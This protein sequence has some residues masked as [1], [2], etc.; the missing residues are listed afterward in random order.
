MPQLKAYHRPTTISEAV[1]L[2]A[3]PAVNTR[4]IGGGTYAIPH[5]SDVVDEVV[6]LQKIGL[7]EITT[8]QHGLNVGAMVTLQT[9]TTDARLPELLRQTAQQ[10]GPNTLRQAAT[11]GG[12]VVGANKESELLAA[13]LIF[14]A[15]IKVQTSNGSKTVTLTDFLQDVPTALSGGI[16]TT[17]SLT[18]TGQ[19][20]QARAARTPTDN[21]IVAAIA[22][23]EGDGIIQLALCGVAN[24]PVLV[25]PPNIETAINPPADF[26][27]ST[28]YR[29]YLAVTLSQR[30][31]NKLNKESEQ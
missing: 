30:V 4:V 25:H 19:T 11:L 26:R 22:R 5:M 17:I 21:P 6:D 29:R 12:V 18:I 1:Q 23:R 10:A 28:K 13:L 3:R 9:L 7:T 16:I 31:I 27:G 20:A 15:Q 2:L 8:T 24:T 14:D